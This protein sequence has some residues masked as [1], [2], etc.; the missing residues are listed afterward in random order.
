ML[1]INVSSGSDTAGCFDDATVTNHPVSPTLKTVPNLVHIL[2]TLMI[3]RNK[4][5]IQIGQ[6]SLNTVLWQFQFQ[7]VRVC[8]WNCT[9]RY[10]HEVLAHGI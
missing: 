10:R 1:N 6:P 8:F 5:C 9:H 2:V 7:F 3:T 4:C